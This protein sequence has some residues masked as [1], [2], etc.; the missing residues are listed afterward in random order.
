VVQLNTKA[1]TAPKKIYQHIRNLR[2]VI[3]TLT[4]AD[5]MPSS[6]DVPPFDSLGCLADNYLN[7]HGFDD[8]SL[9][10]IHHAIKLAMRSQSVDAFTDYLCSREMA[11]REAQFLYWLIS[12]EFDTTI[13]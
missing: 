11:L 1:S 6:S 3:T 8:I 7:C 13:L 9:R 5:A 4:E 2:G 12:F 10:H